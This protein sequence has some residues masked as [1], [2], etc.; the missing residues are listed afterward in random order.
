MHVTV[1]PEN[2]MFIETSQT[3]KIAYWLI[4]SYAISRIDKPTEIEHILG[5]V[6]E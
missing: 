2:I 4:C 1:N 5:V 6:R 3:Q